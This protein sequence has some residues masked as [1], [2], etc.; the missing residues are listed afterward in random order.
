[1]AKAKNT[2]G[3]KIADDDQE[4]GISDISA[5]ATSQ[6]AQAAVTEINDPEA[7]TRAKAT[8]NKIGDKAKAAPLDPAPNNKAK[9]AA[10]KTKAEILATIKAESERRVNYENFLHEEAI[11]GNRY[12]IPSHLIPDG[13]TVEWKTTHVMGKPV[14]NSEI[15]SHEMNGWTPAPAELFIEMMPEGY[16]KPVI[17]RDGMMLYIRPAEITKR[18]RDMEYRNARTAVRNKQNE[19]NNTK[20][21]TMDRIVQQHSVSR[22]ARIAVDED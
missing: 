20:E 15:A 11:K 3:I 8:A 10:K 13:F 14:D 12:D 16:D 4:Q 17:E 2:G 21:G 6:A 9:P 18:F 19:L 22:T 7:L 1:M 5:P